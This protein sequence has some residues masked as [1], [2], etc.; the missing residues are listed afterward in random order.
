M[1]A[2]ITS[3][4]REKTAQVLSGWV[5]LPVVLILIFGGPTVF[6]YSIAAGVNAIGHPFWWRFA[7]GIL[8]ELTGIIFS[9]GLFS[10]QPNEARVLILF[11]EYKGTVRASGFW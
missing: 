9:V 3:V 8:M 1:N 4:N 2:E 11:G 5:M 10:L 6:I 7:L